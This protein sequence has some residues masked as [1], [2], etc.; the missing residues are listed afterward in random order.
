MSDTIREQVIQH[1]AGEMTLADLEASLAAAT[2]DLP[3]TSPDAE[4][5][6]SLQLLL[7]EHAR[8]HR[9]DEEAERGLRRLLWTAHIGAQVPYVTESAAVT[10]RATG[11]TQPRI[12][13]AG[14][15]SL[16][17]RA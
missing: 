10:E 6:Y 9:T 11:W 16:G 7:A 15:R 8:G 4:L 3:P 2:W 5:A 12:V 14:T 17:A 13:A 1:L